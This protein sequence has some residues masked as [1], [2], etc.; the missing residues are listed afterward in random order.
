MLPIRYQKVEEFIDKLGVAKFI[1]VLDLTS[2]VTY[3]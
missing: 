1:A 3:K 2:L